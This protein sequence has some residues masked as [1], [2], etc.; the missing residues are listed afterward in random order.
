[1]AVGKILL[2]VAIGVGA[3]AAAP[4]TGGGSVF[5]GA[6]L[7]ASLTGAGTLATG[8][9]VIGGV[10]GHLISKKEDE[11]TQNK[12]NN[13]FKSGMKA[14]EKATK[15]KFASF[16]QTQRNRDEYLILATYIG[17][18]VAKCDGEF[19]DKEQSEIK[20]YIRIITESP[21]T[22]Q[23]LKSELLRIADSEINFLEVRNAT[24]KFLEGKTPAMKKEIL[25]SLKELID[26]VIR[27]DGNEHPLEKRFLS[28]W[29]ALK[30]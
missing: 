10:A 11:I 2:G 5:G 16:L 14:G 6:T 4:F 30:F 23:K 29:N 28:Q 26:N 21:L 22:P 18:H 1:M 12:S 27:A 7:L 8:A 13:D 15:Q 19:H 25:I 24:V 3:V 20:N 17:V 9:G